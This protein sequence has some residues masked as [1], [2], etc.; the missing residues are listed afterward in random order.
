MNKKYFTAVIENAITLYHYRYNIVVKEVIVDSIR[1]K[2][3]LSDGYDFI[4]EF[5]CRT[6]IDGNVQYFGVIISDK[7]TAVYKRAVDGCRVGT[8]VLEYLER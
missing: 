4:L 6:L 8:V 1:L 3:T 2:S 7:N 5:I